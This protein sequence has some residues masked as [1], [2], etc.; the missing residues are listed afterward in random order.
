ML[1]VSTSML[2][3]APRIGDVLGAKIVACLQ[4]GCPGPCLSLTTSTRAWCCC[5]VGRVNFIGHDHIGLTVYDTFKVRVVRVKSACQL[6]MLTC[7][8]GRAA[9]AGVH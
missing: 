9:M 4:H 2:L 3:F 7:E 1:Q 6:Q 5:T 8:S